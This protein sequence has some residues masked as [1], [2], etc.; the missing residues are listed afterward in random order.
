MLNFYNINDITFTTTNGMYYNHSTKV[1][2][3]SFERFHIDKKTFGFYSIISCRGT[4][5]T[6]L[7]LDRPR[8]SMSLV[9]DS[10][11]SSKLTEF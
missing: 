5:I 7:L 4:V 2:T 8:S 3:I 11:F 10:V 6:R 1:P 9:V